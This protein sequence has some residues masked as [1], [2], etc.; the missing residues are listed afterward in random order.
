[1]KN[2]IYTFAL[3]TALMLHA[4]GGG[5][6]EET[7]TVVEDLPAVLV[8]GTTTLDLSEYYMPFSL[9]VPDSNRGYPDVEET[10]FGETYVRVGATFNMVVAEG[11]DLAAKKQEIGNDLMF[12]NEIVEE[13]EDYFIYKSMI[14]DSFL[15]PEFH[16]Y[17]VKSVNGI[18]FEFRDNKDEGPFA[19][20]IVRFMAE[21]VKHILPNQPAS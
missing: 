13:G 14:K 21:S 6:S 4:C 8:N 19:E 3:F 12:S 2:L 1:M 11:G 18:Q 10:G 17:A 5:E 16:F 7:E 15:D 9:Y 20:S